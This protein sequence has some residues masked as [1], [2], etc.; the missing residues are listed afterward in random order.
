MVGN[1]PPQKAWGMFISSTLCYNCKAKS[2]WR[3]PSTWLWDPSGTCW[4]RKRQT[5]EALFTRRLSKVTRGGV[6]RAY[7]VLLGSFWHHWATGR[8]VSFL[9]SCSSFRK[10]VFALD[11]KVSETHVQV[12][13]YQ[14]ILINNHLPMESTGLCQTGH[15]EC[16]FDLFYSF[17]IF[18]SMVTPLFFVLID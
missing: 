13:I 9:D 18:R 11:C 7:Q 17:C 14:G 12:G 10:T 5:V 15:K 2:R 1:L 4:R 8:V 3:P 16:P 6:I